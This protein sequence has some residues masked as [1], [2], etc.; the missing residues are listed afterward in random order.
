MFVEV[1]YCRVRMFSMSDSASKNMY[2][3][4][5]CLVCFIRLIVWFVCSFCL[6]SSFA[7]FVYSFVLFVLSVLFVLFVQLVLFVGLFV[8][9]RWSMET[10]HKRVP[11][12]SVGKQTRSRCKA[13]R[14]TGNRKPW[15][16]NANAE[17][18]Q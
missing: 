13:E 9:T 12:T 11:E 2:C 7:I 18:H 1:V 5:V 14:L 15:S 6:L 3:L 4:F 10:K 8:G 16:K 17:G